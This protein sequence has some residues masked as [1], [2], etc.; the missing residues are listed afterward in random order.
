MTLDLH[1][2][3]SPHLEAALA[4]R[5]RILGDEHPDTLKATDSWIVSLTNQG[6]Y[7]EAES[8]ARDAFLIGSRTLGPEHPSTLLAANSLACFLTHSQGKHEEAEALMRPA[9]EIALRVLGPEHHETFNIMLH[10]AAALDGQ[11]N[12]HE[13]GED[14]SRQLLAIQRRTLGDEH[15]KTLRTMSYLGRS[16][17]LQGKLNEARPYFTELIRYGRRTAEQPDASK[18][19]L[20]QYA[21]SLLTCELEDLRDPQAALPVAKRAVEMSDGKDSN[22]LDTLALAY[23]MTGDTAKAIE[24]QEKAVSLLPNR[25]DLEA[26]LAKFRAA[27][28]E[29]TAQKQPT[30]TGTNDGS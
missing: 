11:P 29:S 20:N 9:L 21:W 3:A 14:M 26:N 5:R 1:D 19:G 7:R 15:I 30:S 23:F 8:L 27:A 16:L 2:A 6:K 24:T 18:N 12:K 10:L 25:T 4:I 22:F 28:A 17:V 13:E